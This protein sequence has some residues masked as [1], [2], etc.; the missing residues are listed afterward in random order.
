MF[1]LERQKNVI[2]FISIST[3]A[4]VRVPSCKLQASQW[5]REQQL[6]EHII[7][8]LEILAQYLSIAC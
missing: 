5:L 7:M 2:L 1:Y 4:V 6:V 8:Y 3:S